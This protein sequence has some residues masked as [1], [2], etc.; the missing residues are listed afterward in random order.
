MA[1]PGARRLVPKVGG[2][3]RLNTGPLRGAPGGLT[4][5]WPVSRPPQ[6]RDHMNVY[7]Y[8]SIYPRSMVVKPSVKHPHYSECSVC[9]PIYIHVPTPPPTK[10]HPPHPHHPPASTTTHP[11]H[12]TLP[13]LPPPRPPRSPPGPPPSPPSPPRAACV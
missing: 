4:V 7:I 11:P 8:L 2:P 9:P 5:N 1:A 13:P 6:R 3:R 12:P 10:N